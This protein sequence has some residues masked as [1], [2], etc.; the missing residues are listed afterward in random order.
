MLATSRDGEYLPNAG[1][2]GPV[3][4]IATYAMYRVLDLAFDLTRIELSE[5]LVNALERFG[6]SHTLDSIYALFRVRQSLCGVDVPFGGIKLHMLVHMPHFIRLYGC[7]A[8]WDT[9]SFESAH[10]A[11]VKYYYTTGSKRLQGLVQN[12]MSKVRN[13]PHT[14]T[15]VDIMLSTDLALILE[16][17]LP[18]IWS[19]TQRTAPNT[20]IKSTRSW[21]SAGC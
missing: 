14:L 2:Y 21:N 16:P 11:F 3:K 9:S 10:K 15:S 18:N 6:I 13:R 12:I 20:R 8:N 7:P 17:A 1:N 5:Q 4:D 19:S